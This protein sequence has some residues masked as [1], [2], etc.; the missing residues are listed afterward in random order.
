MDESTK[1]FLFVNEFCNRLAIV[2]KGVREMRGWYVFEDKRPGSI[3]ERFNADAQSW[4]R[5]TKMFENC[6]L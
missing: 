2:D 4:G 3:V 1:I 6:I 5:Y